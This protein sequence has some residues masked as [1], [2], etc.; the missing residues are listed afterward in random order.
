MQIVIEIDDELYEEILSRKYSKTKLENAVA[1][2]TPLPQEQ[3]PCE[4][5]VSRSEVENILHNT[6]YDNA[7]HDKAYRVLGLVRKQVDNLPSVTPKP[8]MGRWIALENEEMETV[9]YYCSECDLPMETE[10]RTNFCPNC[11]ARMEESEG[12]NE[13]I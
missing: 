11:G 10:Q 9:G 12:K 5:C 2:G 13:E 1:D 3:E 7:T 8:K 4:D 6:M